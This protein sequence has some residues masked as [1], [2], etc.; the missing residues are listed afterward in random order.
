MRGRVVGKVGW[1]ALR[2]D[3]SG[4][5]GLRPS[6]C[7]AELL[8]PRRLLAAAPPVLV[9]DIN[10][11]SDMLGPESI[12]P[13]GSFALF[14]GHHG[15]AD[16]SELMRTDGTKAGTYLVK[17]I[18]PGLAGSG[19]ANLTNA[20]G[21][22][23][24]A[25][26][27]ADGDRE[28]WKSDGTAA[29]TVRVKNIRATGSSNPSNFGAIGG[30]VY[31]SADDGTGAK[32]WKSDGT[33][34][35]TVVVPGYTSPT[36][37]TPYN[38][39]LAFLTAGSPSNSVAVIKPD[40]TAGG[41]AS[42]GATTF[43]VMNGAVYFFGAPL[44]SGRGD[45]FRTDGT[46]TTLVKKIDYG[47]SSDY[48]ASGG[49]LR[50]VVANGNM[51]YF[52]AGDSSTAKYDLWRSDGTEAG[53]FTV[54]GGG[55]IHS[56][57]YLSP[58][59]PSGVMFPFT[60]IA[61][62][63]EPWVSDGTVAGTKLLKDLAPGAASGFGG[64]WGLKTGGVTY[65]TPQL[66]SGDGTL[67]KTDGTTAGTTLV[68]DVVETPRFIQPIG[69]LNG[70]V[71]LVAGSV[72]SD[73][74]LYR[75]D[76]T[77]A[78]TYRVGATLGGTSH[79]MSEVPPTNYA[80]NAFLRVGETMYF[81]ATDGS[82]GQELWRT[83]PTGGAVRLT[84]LAPGGDSSD[85]AQF[86]LGGD[87]SIYFTAATAADGT[88]GLYRIPPG[89]TT[90][91]LIPTVGPAIRPTAVGNVLYFSRSIDGYSSTLY[92]YNPA[93]NAVT[94][95]LASGGTR[96]SSVTRMV[97]AGTSIYFSAKASYGNPVKLWRLDESATA[98]PVQVDVAGGYA[99]ATPTPIA[100]VGSTL[101]FTAA[102]AAT[103][104]E[105][106]ATDGT[107]A[108]TRR[109]ADLAPGTA[110]S[111][112]ESSYA[113]S[114]AAGGGGVLYFSRGT[115]SES[116]RLW[117]SDGTAAGTY[118][119]GDL[120][121][122]RWFVE[123]AGAAYFIA[124]DNATGLRSLYRTDGDDTNG[125]TR[126]TDPGSGDTRFEPTALHAAANGNVYAIGWAGAGTTQ[127]DLW[128]TRG[129]PGDAERVT[130]F[131]PY[132]RYDGYNA[133]LPSTF[134]QGW[135]AMASNATDLYVPL[136]TPQ[137]GVEPHRIAL[138][139]AQTGSL[140]IR[141][142]VYDDVNRDGSYGS[143]TGEIPVGGRTV[144]LDTDNDGSV[145]TGE[146]T[147]QTNLTNG[148]GGEFRFDNLAPGRYYVRTV[149]PTNW[150]QTN[151]PPGE[152][153][154]V[155]LQAGS[156]NFLY[157]GTHNL[158]QAARISGTVFQD[159]DQD[160]VR[161]TGEPGI[162]GRTVYID[163]DD[164]G[165]LDADELSAT[166]D[167]SGVYQLN[168][169]ATATTTFRVRQ[170]LP[171]GGWV[172]TLPATGAARVVTAGPREP[173]ALQDFG[174]EAVAPPANNAGR[175][176][177]LDEGG[178]AT[179][180]G[181]AFGG[182]PI[183]AHEWDMNY[184]GVTFHVDATGTQATYS[185]QDADGPTTRT[186]AYRARDAYGRYTA[187]D[188]RVATVRNIA[189]AA[190][191][192]TNSGPVFAGAASATVSFAGATDAAPADVAA[193]LLFSYDF[194]NDGTF[195]VTGSTEPQA[196]VPASL[197]AT[198]GTRTIHGRVADKDGGFTD[199]LTDLVVNPPVD[200][201]VTRVF[202]AGS[203]WTQAFRGHLQQVSL[204]E[205]AFG[206]AID[207]AAAADELPWTNLNQVSLRFSQNVSV[208]QGNLV[209]TG[210]NAATYA[211]SAFAYDA[212]T[213]TATWNLNTSGIANDKL[214]LTL[215][216]AATATV[217]LNVLPG[218]VNRSGGSVIGSDVTL[219]RN[220]Q[221]S[222]PGGVNSLYTIF[223]DVN[224]SGSILGSD[225]TAVRNRQGLSLPA[226]EPAA[227]HA[228]LRAEGPA[229]ARRLSDGLI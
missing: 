154:V 70:V 180:L 173:A 168:P 120:G 113:W 116:P 219:V 191:S 43:T 50:G 177:A 125:A 112:I 229:R 171:P 159:V 178:N 29:G 98:V 226:G 137:F 212:A 23:F 194:N 136:Y 63:T 44:T 31:F 200:P 127:L 164:D 208:A 145:D 158:A 12:T 135:Y 94:E 142:V 71:M 96:M 62:G 35:G 37:M 45:L 87:G 188:E 4:G 174:A 110:S 205:T 119:V 141:G 16:G 30:T 222:P 22:V 189:P 57:T 72:V 21:T 109:V 106:W 3:A 128:H 34:A 151:P 84:D 56:Q 78:G 190:S 75:S 97:R 66:G 5:R 76:G 82:T 58:A 69:T 90:P 144:W 143:T 100:A 149:I 139:A 140:S 220:A 176:I 13:V 130:G 93:T 216:G 65:F 118:A 160:G 204:G 108:N 148:T 198:Q 91:V 55:V 161:D 28:L 20:N 17:D 39:G 183:V 86:A 126:L 99:S 52:R 60:T 138:P 81:A 150:V 1:S 202:V 185:A 104:R 83:D 175:D 15:P 47:G 54:V 67:W 199:Y 166:T 117:R 192:F 115:S 123:S 167:G 7:A 155:D 6:S 14:A 163:A 53:T 179:V 10:T 227:L 156:L 170:V 61:A 107:A 73:G 89:G 121:S 8:E 36:S 59:G 147:F 26:T 196:T 217:R 33:E 27:D 80:S 48:T 162:A 46:T 122:P 129:T 111:E 49:G 221:N 201:L 210:L 131:T 101:F 206:F 214:L 2:R 157:I 19:P 24:F 152:P 197:L 77:A 133:F 224:G 225:V 195:D 32:L 105:L 184:D 103:G 41:V 186:F 165:T 146:P 203:T 40:G 85:P 182:A 187:P 207:P 223:K 134:L 114:A 51:L 209:V 88:R 169:Y 193:G 11:T 153:V 79:G 68:K 95:V 42:P 102:D 18:R 213:F 211:V 38:G 25:A 172:Q 181:S 218:D 9:R 124:A 215:T 74:D 92:R 228:P 64:N 132:L